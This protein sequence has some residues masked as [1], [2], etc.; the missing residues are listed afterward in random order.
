MD[1][2]NDTLKMPVET[3]DNPFI[4]QLVEEKKYVESYANKFDASMIHDVADD[5]G[6]KID[7]ESHKEHPEV[8]ADDVM[9]IRKRRKM[10][11]KELMDTVSL[12]TLTTSKDSHKRRRISN[13]APPE[14]EKRVKRHK[15]SKSSMSARGSSSEQSAKDSTTYVSKQQKQQR[16]WDA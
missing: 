8:V 3:P 4:K 5:F 2:F 6:D 13:D 10:K 14:G 15:T 16:E 7:P 9:M 1:M 11:W 12:S